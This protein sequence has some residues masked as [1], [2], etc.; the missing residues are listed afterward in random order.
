MCLS[1]N[2]Y[3]D[4]CFFVCFCMIRIMDIE[5]LKQFI[6][7]YQCRNSYTNNSMCVTICKPIY[8]SLNISKGIWTFVKI[9]KDISCYS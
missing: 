5:F 4:T 9:Y 8:M 2:K 3:N 7:I 1:F 6:K